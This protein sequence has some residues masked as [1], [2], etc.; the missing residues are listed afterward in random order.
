MG[1][2]TY[3]QLFLV[4]DVFIIGVLT[5]IAYRHARE[6][7]RPVKPEPPKP[8]L[9]G[10]VKERMLLA[11]EEQFKSVLQ[12]SVG[13]LEHDL[14][15]TTEQINHLIKEF[16]GEIVGDELE[17]YRSELTK[18]HKQAETDMSGIS[19]ELTEHQAEL[20][21]NLA[22]EMEAEKQVLIK[23]IDTKLADAVGSFLVETLQHNVDLGN[24]SEFLVAMLEEHKDVFKQEVTAP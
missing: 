5:P 15:S 6:H 13:H 21:A 3:L 14:E 23:Q 17:R 4:L 18:L 9:P 2:N 1:I 22:A 20:K 24:Q 10:T 8:Q 19:R 11:S 16:A 7:Y 12:K